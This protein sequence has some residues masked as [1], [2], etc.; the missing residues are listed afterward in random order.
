MSKTVKLKISDLEKIVKN[1]LKEAE[2]DD[3][4]TKVQPEEL[5]DYEDYEAEREMEKSGDNH[6]PENIVVGKDQNGNI[7]VMDTEKG[8][9]LGMKKL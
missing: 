6:N 7:V 3:F 8:E 9:I 4:D 1:V 2:F 5:P